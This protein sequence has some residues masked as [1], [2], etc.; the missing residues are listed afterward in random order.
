[1]NLFAS[2]ADFFKPDPLPD[3]RVR[4]GLGRVAE[5]VSPL[6]QTTSGFNSKLVG[7]LQHAIGYCDGVV[8]SVPGPVDI[9][10]AAFSADPLVHALF[11]TAD[12]I[13]QMLGRSQAVRDYLSEPCSWESDH[14]YA[15]FAA[16]RLQKKQL[17]VANH[18]CVIHSEVPQLV[19]YF[20][21]H[22]LIEPHCT[23]EETLSALRET[24][25]DSLLKAFHEHVETLRCERDGLRSDLSVERAHLTLLR[26]KT[27]GHEYEVRT[28]HLAELDA[29]L[30]ETADLLMP[31][32]LVS[33]L[34][35]FLKSPEPSLHLQPV[36]L[37]LDRLGIVCNEGDENPDANTL[38]FPELST[39]DKRLHTVLLARI[40]RDEALEAVELVRDQ[41]HRFMLI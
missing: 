22:T 11:A 14:F 29:R 3:P 36:H 39:R 20:S 31:D 34:A 18:G 21:N 5:L 13:D 33:T 40:S 26:G 16:R 19:V 4:R 24:A 2:V 30:R 32:Q 6:L 38:E 28:R 12:D 10:R 1:V 37:R 17:G 41:Q 9:S 15:L 27:G 8:A 7:P 23:L 35:E 25:L